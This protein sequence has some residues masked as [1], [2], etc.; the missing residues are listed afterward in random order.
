[1]RIAGLDACK[2][3][4]SAFRPLCS[5]RRDSRNSYRQSLQAIATA[6]RTRNKLARSRIAPQ[7][8]A[9]SVDNPP[10]SGTL[11]LLLGA[12]KCIPHLTFF[13]GQGDEFEVLITPLWNSRKDQSFNKPENVKTLIDKDLSSM[14]PGAVETEVPVQQFKRADG[15]GYYFLV[16]DRA[17]KP[18]EY[19]Y[20][21]RAVVGVDDLLL[22]VTI[23]RHPDL[24]DIV[25][26]P[27]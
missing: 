15:I 18:G 7:I 13:P 19:P 6:T 11:Y 27:T 20:V 10:Y 12:V 4:K 16:T 26:R 3:C 2:P 8:P 1:M 24:W 22:S 17:P 9:A 21:V 23:L 5:I 25:M 14:L